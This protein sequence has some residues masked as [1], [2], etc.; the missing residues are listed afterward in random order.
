MRNHSAMHAS[1]SVRASQMRP[2][3][4]VVVSLTLPDY[5]PPAG[6]GNWRSM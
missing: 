6:A 3:V 1:S 4:V 2:A 5:D